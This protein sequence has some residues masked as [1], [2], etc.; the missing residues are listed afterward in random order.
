MKKRLLLIASVLLM[1]LVWAGV[2]FAASPKHAT[3]VEPGFYVRI[4]CRSDWKEWACVCC[5]LYE[6]KDACEKAGRGECVEYDPDA[7]SDIVA[8]APSTPKGCTGKD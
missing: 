5:K 4:K 1:A 6:T 3:L 7:D 8:N 2:Q